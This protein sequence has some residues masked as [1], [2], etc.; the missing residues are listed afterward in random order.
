MT[1][2]LYTLLLIGV[3]M[4]Q[5]LAQHIATLPYELYDNT[6]FIKVSIN[7]SSPLNFMFDTGAGIIVMNQSTSDFIEFNRSG[8]SRVST[9]GR[10]IEAISTVDNILTSGSLELKQ[11]EIELMPLDHLSEY[12]G[13]SV[14]GII[15][16]DLFN[17][18]LLKTDPEAKT[19][20]L[21]ASDQGMG[22]S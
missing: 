12:F 5:G 2:A 7:N 9:S 18:Y 14:D 22:L 16:Y 10:V 11:L 15:G 4:S 17:S 21:Y 13:I 8:T 6:I 19:I 20:E 1:R 3:M